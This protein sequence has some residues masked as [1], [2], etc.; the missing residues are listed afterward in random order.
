MTSPSRSERR[1]VSGLI[2]AAGK[3]SRMKSDLPKVLHPICGLPMLEFSIRTL[4]ALDA[5]TVGVV[6]GAGADR[7]RSAFEDREVGGSPLLWGLQNPPNGT[8]D[9]VRV[10]LE[11][12]E[13][14]ESS[15]FV[16]N[17]DLPLLS[18]RSLT[19][20]LELHHSSEAALT[21][22]T[23]DL[24]DPTGYGRIVRDD[25]GAVSDIV[26]Q[27]DADAATLAIREVNGGVYL[28]EPGPLRAALKEWI[29]RAEGNSQGEI[30][31]P[32]VVRVLSESGQR[33]VAFELPSG[34]Q[35]ELQQVNDRVE[36]AKATAIRSAQ[37]I[38]DHQRNG[39]TVVDP[40]TTTIEEDV[41]IGRDSTI[42]P[43]TV[44][45][46]GVEVGEQCEVGPFAQLRVGTV[47]GV[48]SAIGNFT[49]VKNTTLGAGSKAKHLTYLG[50]GRIGKGVNVG[51][52]TILANYDG[53]LKSTTTIGDGAFI[54]SG[55][56]LVAPVEVGENAQ[57]GAGSVVTRGRDVPAGGTVIG[58]P[59]KPLKPRPSEEK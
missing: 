17:G 22:L 56:I 4:E 7:V 59:A 25:T 42:H 33:V 9:A 53:K 20:M 5:E 36:L 18:H 32:P 51:A 19:E 21:L 35:D 58:V 43:C 13:A 41:S 16:L 44:I 11:A 39:V 38:V 27:A 49:E 26:E 50:D 55:T 34:R 24:E 28:A 48:G 30:Y 3:G 57:T 52:G 10:G 1:P 47:M 15:L 40:V 31:F 2:L 6:I 37:I 8:G 14:V 45:R 12:L 23:L 29:E 46:S 54:G